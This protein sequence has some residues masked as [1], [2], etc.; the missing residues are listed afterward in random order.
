M[1]TGYINVWLIF[2]ITLIY[3]MIILGGYTR[4]S[5]SG[6]SIV[7][8]APISGT[9]PPLNEQEWLLEFAK[10][11]ESPEFKHVNYGMD[12]GKFKKIFL[13]EF[14]HRLLGR[15]IGMSFL[16][17][18]LYFAFTKKISKADIKYFS[19]VF[20]LISFQGLMGWLMVKSGL[21]N[22]PHVSQYRL[23]AHLLLACIILILLFWKVTP[24]ENKNSSYANFSLGLLL[25][26]ITSG[27]FV[28]GLK[29]GLVYNSFPLMEGNLIP[30]GLFILN[31]LHLNFFENVTM[32]QF[33][34]RCLG[35]INLINIIFYCYKLFSHEKQK[36]IAILLLSFIILQFLLGIFTLILQTPLILALL[37]QAVAIILMLTLVASLKVKSN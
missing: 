32:V 19:F 1:K 6:L 2:C 35:I 27:A 14:A 4:L 21:S 30:G 37:H 16:I 15:F 11:K 33:L 10:Y 36:N 31:P 34:H 5:N 3:A 25:L 12:L 17:P 24:G 28:A 22:A 29:A 7:E 23:A 20:L 18:F 8:W 9:L 26:Q 13:V